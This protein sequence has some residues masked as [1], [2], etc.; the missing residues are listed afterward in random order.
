MLAFLT[1]NWLGQRLGQQRGRQQQ[2]PGH[3]RQ[4]IRVLVQLMGIQQLKGT[5]KAAEQ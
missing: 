3:S 4:Q 1:V 5:E 2:G